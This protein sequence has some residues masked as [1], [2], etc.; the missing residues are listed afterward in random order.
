MTFLLHDVASGLTQNDRA[1]AE[2]KLSKLAKLMPNLEAVQM[3][4]REDRNDHCAEL[5]LRGVT[6]VMRICGKAKSVRQAVDSAFLRAAAK[7]RRL[8]DRQV[9]RRSS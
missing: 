1:Y 6:G 5:H 7:L 9:R 2:T 4:H 8:R 3:V